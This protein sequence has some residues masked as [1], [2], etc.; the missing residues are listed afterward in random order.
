MCYVCALPLEFRVREQGGRKGT[1]KIPKS[2]TS[3]DGD[4]VCAIPLEFSGQRTWDADIRSVPSSPG[5]GAPRAAAPHTSPTTGLSAR[6]RCR[7][8]SLPPGRPRAGG[9]ESSRASWGQGRVWGERARNPRYAQKGASSQ[10]HTQGSG[11]FHEWCDRDS[12]LWDCR[13][14]LWSF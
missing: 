3:I 10:P 13:A 2:H 14:T 8:G 4:M 9:S 7:C 12:S 11:L 1:K 5:E 6:R